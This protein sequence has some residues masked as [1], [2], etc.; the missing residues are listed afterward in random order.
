MTIPHQIS[1]IEKSSPAAILVLIRIGMRVGGSE[2]FT[3]TFP[4]S[5]N[6]LRVMLVFDLA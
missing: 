4:T 2:G 3:G 1:E 6:W 5:H